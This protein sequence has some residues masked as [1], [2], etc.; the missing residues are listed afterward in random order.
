MQDTLARTLGLKFQ[1]DAINYERDHFVNSD[2]PLADLRDRFEAG[3]SDQEQELD[4]MM[5]MLEG[6]GFETRVDKAVLLKL[7]RYFNG[8]RPRYQE[9]L[10]NI[11]GVETEMPFRSRCVRRSSS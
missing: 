6:T 1:L 7:K 4:R 9:F 10:S 3:G 2:L 8:V 5:S 11:T